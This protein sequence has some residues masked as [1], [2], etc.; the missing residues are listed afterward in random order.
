M[1]KKKIKGLLLKSVSNDDKRNMLAE[2]GIDILISDG[3]NLFCVFFLSL[4]LLNTK[5]TV[6]YML[7]L[8]TLRVHSGGWHASSELR[9][10]ITYQGMFLL[11]SLLNTLI[12]PKHVST[13]RL[14]YQMPQKIFK[15]W[16]K[17]VNSLTTELV[18]EIKDYHEWE[19]RKEKTAYK[20]LNDHQALEV[21]RLEATLM[22][23]ELMNTTIINATRYNANEYLDLFPYQ[24]KPTNSIEHLIG[25][26]HRDSV[27]SFKEEVDKLMREKTPLTRNLARWVTRNYIV[28]SRNMKS[29]DRQSLN[30]KVLNHST[31]QSRLIAEQ[32]RNEKKH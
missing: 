29:S 10:F 28:N 24:E 19:Y 21:L 12:I 7:V 17:E 25:L 23:L 8:S 26:R 1:L 32:H 15:A 3:R 9:C 2:H 31:S 6:L 27:E 20:P 14:I 18:R 13:V 16:A 30:S 11:F 4:F 22:M 5:E